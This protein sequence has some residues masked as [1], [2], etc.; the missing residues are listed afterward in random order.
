MIRN[1]RKL[2]TIL[3]VVF[4]CA[5]TKQ[6]PDDVVVKCSEL[7]VA[8]KAN[9]R[10]CSKEINNYFNQFHPSYTL[11]DVKEYQRNLEIESINQRLANQEWEIEMQRRRAINAAYDLENQNAAPTSFS[12]MDIQ[13]GTYKFCNKFG[14]SVTC[15]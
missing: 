11:R 9:S 2:L 10:N 1:F 12:I 13:T 4:L 15:N 3:L 6:N 7:P 14:S 8:L 5:C